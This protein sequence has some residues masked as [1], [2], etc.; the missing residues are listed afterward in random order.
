MGNAQGQSG[1]LPPLSLTDSTFASQVRN[2][3][4]LWNCLFEENRILLCPISKSLNTD[5]FNKKMI[6]SHILEPDRI[7]GEYKTLRNE[8]VS[9]EGNELVCGAGFVEPRRVKVQNVEQVE[10]PVTNISFV[11]F[12]ISR[13]LSGG[14]LA[15]EEA[16]HM[17]IQ[18]MFKYMAFV[19]TSTGMY[20]IY[21]HGFIEVFYL[22]FIC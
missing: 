20:F 11:V 18:M 5:D 9:M 8:R 13:P 10:D 7:G 1:K 2:Y 19:R 15:P 3:P 12:I 4:D 21:G 22:G 14:L 17:T 16:D 6:M